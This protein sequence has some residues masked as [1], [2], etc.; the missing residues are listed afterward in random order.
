MKRKISFFVGL[1]MV[2][3]VFFVASPVFA[4][5]ADGTY[6]ISYEMK[7]AN[8]ENTSI[9]D[10]YFTKPATLTVENGV[11][12][13]Q[14]MLTG[15]NYIQ[16]LSAPSGPVTV[17]GEDTANDTRS[18]QFQVDGDLSNP[19]NM[20]MHIIVPAE[21][22]PP[23]GYDMTH[24]ARAV[25]DVSGLPQAADAPANDAT[26]TDSDESAAADDSNTTGG[27]G[28][29]EVVENPKTGEN[30]PIMLYALLMLA[31][32]AGLVAVWKLKPVRNE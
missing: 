11:Q 3:S 30:T 15:A 19:V 24:T 28:E 16:S 9:A 21:A 27:S 12:H 8:S 1:V 26:E 20:E 2:L 23:N 18:V 25:F 17:L 13:I 22:L 10:G 6:E 29:A 7:E 4:Q 5:I 32:G 31:A 14:I